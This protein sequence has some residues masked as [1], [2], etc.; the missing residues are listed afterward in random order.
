M[1]HDNREV[2]ETA[3]PQRCDFCGK[4]SAEVTIQRQKFLYGSGGTQVEL[5]AEVPV[6]TC[7][8]CGEQS[9]GYG[10]E[11][12]RHDA[13]CRY[14]NRLTP[15]E[16]R[17]IREAY[18]LTQEEFSKLTGFGSASIKR[19]ETGANIQ[20]E[21]ADP[22]LRLFAYPDN[23]ARLGKDNVHSSSAGQQHKFRNEI[24]ETTRQDAKVFQLRPSSQSHQRKVA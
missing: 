5:E 2:L 6:Q 3:N 20:N 7:D 12:R 17:G 13:V 24:P 19:W 21:S 9:T 1:M 23:L 4:L 8:A 18:N 10:A 15:R 16:V 22:F 14:L 11:E